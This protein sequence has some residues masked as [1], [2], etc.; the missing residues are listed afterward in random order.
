[1]TESAQ[2]STSEAATAR[3][4]ELSADG[5][6]A[7]KVLAQDPTAFGELQNLTKTIAKEPE[8]AAGTAEAMA[9]ETSRTND[10]KMLNDYLAAAGENGFPELTSVVGKDMVEML[11]GKPVSQEIHDAVK[12]K[13]DSML[14]DKDWVTRFENREQR[15]MREFQMA[16]VVL[17]APVMEKA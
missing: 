9:L 12:V 16:T 3:L 6:W 1:V 13:L 14:K 17:T 2:P 10:A 8:P 11:N 15:A 4:N 7:G 5:A